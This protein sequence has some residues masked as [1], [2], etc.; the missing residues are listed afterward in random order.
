MKNVQVRA[1]AKLKAD[2]GKKEKVL[3]EKLTLALNSKCRVTTVRRSLSSDSSSTKSRRKRN[4]KKS[5]R[6]SRSRSRDRSR[7]RYSRSRRSRSS[8]SSIYKS[9]KSRSYR[10]SS[11]DRHSERYRRSRTRSRD[12]Y[13]SRRSRSKSYIREYVNKP[14]RRSTSSSSSSSGDII[15]RES[16]KQVPRKKKEENSSKDSVVKGTKS[17]KANSPDCVVID[18]EVLEEINE[19]SFTP[20]QF[21]S[22]KSKK[23][24]ENIVI[25]LKK[26]T[27]KVPEVEQ[28][29]PDSIFHHNLFLS[30][31]A[32]MEKWV[33]ELY[34]FRQ[35]ALQQGM[36]NDR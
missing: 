3:V 21:T 25:D 26:N 31:E 5:S 8:S 9:S 14:R 16:S 1:Q 24:P 13:R 12:R 19:N 18:S 15:K 11:R 2:V 17:E 4:D 35:K 30:E 10:S 23:V 33:R 20:K 27:I 6:R 28:L 34:S 7:D 22:N 36:K 32:R 29:E